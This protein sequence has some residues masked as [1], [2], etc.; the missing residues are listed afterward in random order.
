MLA[1]VLATAS[2]VMAG[3]VP[4]IRVFA[5]S[6]K[7]DVDAAARLSDLVL[8]TWIASLS[9]AMT[10][11]ANRRRHREEPKRRRRDPVIS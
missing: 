4:A 2:S 9:L 1:R 10:A 5:A 11:A 3:L 7:V 8:L 6:R